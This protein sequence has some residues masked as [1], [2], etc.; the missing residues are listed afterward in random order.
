M[1]R[2][3]GIVAL[4]KDGGFGFLEWSNKSEKLY[5]ALADVEDTAGA[6]KDVVEDVRLSKGRE[7]VRPGARCESFA[8]QTPKAHSQAAADFRSWLH[9]VSARVCMCVCV[10]VCVYSRVL[11][12]S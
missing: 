12:R 8:R 6:R 4:I 7:S 1:H 5:F 3:Q 11:R 10:R 9:F 2:R